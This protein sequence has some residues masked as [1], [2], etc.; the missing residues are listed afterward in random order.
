MTIK[1]KDTK[2]RLAQALASA[3]ICCKMV[4]ELPGGI[5]LKA[6]TRRRPR[7]MSEIRRLTERSAVPGR[8][9]SGYIPTLDGWRAVAIVM[10]LACH[11]RDGLFGVNGIIALPRLN[12]LFLNGYL[13]VD[14][15]FSISGFLITSKLLEE[16][17]LTGAVDL[18][19]FYWRRLFRIF[20]ASWVYLGVMF[21][22]A[23][24]G[25]IV[26]RRVK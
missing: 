6:P 12:A 22:C 2:Y 7:T 18:Q 5:L 10:V 15:F 13:G 9:N 23:L 25:V 3:K 4:S 19:D 20:P 8:V 17:L 16:N 1:S 26:L 11:A 24:A 21:L 14:V